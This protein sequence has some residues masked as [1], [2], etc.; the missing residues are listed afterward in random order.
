MD[1]SMSMVADTLR[2]QLATSELQQWLLWAVSDTRSDDWPLADNSL[3]G[4]AG[5]V[6]ALAKEDRRKFQV[7]QP[8]WPLASPPAVRTCY[9]AAW[10]PLPCRSVAAVSSSDPTHHD[11]QDG[12]QLL[13]TTAAWQNELLML[14]TALDQPNQSISWTRSRMI[15]LF[16][17][18]SDTP[19]HFP[20]PL[21][22]TVVLLL[23]HCLSPPFTA[24]HRPSSWCCVRLAPAGAPACTSG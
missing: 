14:L 5:H 12:F 19:R 7:G 9:P 2:R 3:S 22:S 1:Q 11:V 4:F 15:E 10:P 17:V 23:R 16:T 8:P 24:C 20:R 21:R 13:Q 6:C 18:G